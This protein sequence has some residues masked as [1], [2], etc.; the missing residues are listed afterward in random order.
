MAR[1]IGT[2]AITGWS[3]ND[4]SNSITGVEKPKSKYFYPG[5]NVGGPIPLP[6]SGYNKDGK[7]LVFWF[8]LEAQRQQY[9]RR[10]SPEHHD[11]RGARTGDLSEFLA[12]RGQNLNHPAVVTIPGGFP[13]EGTPAPNNDLTPYVTPL[14]RAMASLYPLSELPRSRQPLQLRVQRAVS[15]QPRRITAAGRLEHQQ[16]R[17]GVRPPGP[18]TRKTSTFTRAS[19]AASR[20]LELATPVVGRNRGRSYAANLVAGAEP[21]DDQREP[22]VVH[23]AEARQSLCRSVTTPEGCAGSRLRGLLSAIRVHTSRWT[24]STAGAAASSGTTGRAATT[25]TRTAA[26][27]CSVTS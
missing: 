19:G 13:G 16:R 17:Q 20:E 5:G 1:R 3:A 4:R 10:Q 6:G 14:G 12:N 25:C 22:G 27:C 15:D 21:D 2:G 18:S 8:G 11:Q 7:R 23:R 26:S 9:R 24:T